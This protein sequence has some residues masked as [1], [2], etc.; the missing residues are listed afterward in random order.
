MN[1]Q[2][3]K[4]SF[5][6]IAL[7]EEKS[8]PQCLG[9]VKD[10]VDEIILLDTGSS[11]RTVEVAGELGAKVYNFQWC[12]D[13]AAARNEALKYVTGD[14]VLILDADEVLTTEIVAD[15]KLAIAKED[16]LV[17]NL[18][19]QEV[20]ATQS[21][22]SSVS[23]LFRLHPAVKFNRPYHAS[24]DDSIENILK[25]EKHWQ[26]VDLA[27]VAILHYGYRPEAIAALNK[28][29][30]AKTAMESFL[31]RHPHD[32]YTCSKLG[33]L[34]L[35]IDREKAGFKLLK[36]GLKSN[37]A[38]A[39]VAFELHYHLANFYSRN[40]NF[41]K[42]LKHYQK[43]IS[44]PIIPL[45][46]IGAY[47]NL[48]SVLQLLGD[49]ERA[50]A[51]YLLALKIAP[52]F[53]LGYY[54]LGKVYK[55]KGLFVDAIEAYQK[56]INLNPNYAFAYQ[57]LAVV[58]LKI[59]QLPESIAAFQKAIELHQNQNNPQEAARLRQKLQQMGFAKI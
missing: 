58:L 16:N 10:L 38:D 31:A 23:R 26:I 19:R 18:I 37:Q 1:N 22:Y 46:K 4:L 12:N 47:N 35:Q 3:T 53:A 11:D 56:A 24:I 33:A 55:Q 54:N 39:P 2:M 27:K 44:Q 41:E 7:N 48:G 9:S 57:N 50:E 20:G 28:F 15:L 6:A 59:G 25:Q 21:P 29:D 45:L 49:L 32:P 8:L 52:D 51:S 17:V 40:S 13:F 30:R 34:Y 42:A 14:W 43:A 36:Q 5:C